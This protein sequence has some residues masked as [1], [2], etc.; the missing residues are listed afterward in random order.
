M[1]IIEYRYSGFSLLEFQ[2]YVLS[3]ALV[4]ETKFLAYT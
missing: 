1:L 3:F 2:Y 4:S